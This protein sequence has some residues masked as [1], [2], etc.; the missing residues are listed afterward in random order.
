MREVFLDP[1]RTFQMKQC[2]CAYV[3]IAVGPCIPINGKALHKSLQPAAAAAADW[4]FQTTQ[5]VE[6]KRGSFHLSSPTLPAVIRAE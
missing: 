5:K 4:L 1:E 2:S 6:E 3:R